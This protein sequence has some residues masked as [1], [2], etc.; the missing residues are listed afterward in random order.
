MLLEVRIIVSIGGGWSYYKEQGGSFQGADNVL[1][2]YLSAIIWVC[3]FCEIQWSV[4]VW[5][6]HFYDVR[7]TSIKNNQKRQSASK[8]HTL[9]HDNILPVSTE[10]QSQAEIQMLGLLISK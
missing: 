10:L 5:F 1:S 6:V 4:H 7:Y 8:Y 2:L 3:S 9:N